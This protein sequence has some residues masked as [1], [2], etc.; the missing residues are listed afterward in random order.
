M[1]KDYSVTSLAGALIWTA[2]VV[3]RRLSLPATGIIRFIVDI[4]PN[5]GVIW[6]IVGLTVTFLPYFTKKEFPPQR[7]YLLIGVALGLVLLSEIAHTLL[8]NAA[9][10]VW[11]L[12]A[13]LVAAGWLVAEHVLEQRK[14]AGAGSTVSPGEGL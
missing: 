6:L 14:N 13:S 5:F 4:L 11:D 1:K 8:L 10:D 12:V 2:V 7:M 9:F 3:L